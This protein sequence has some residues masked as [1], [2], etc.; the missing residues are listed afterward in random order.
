MEPVEK[1]LNLLPKPTKSK[2]FKF[3]DEK[4]DEIC[5]IFNSN[6][7]YENI[8]QLT[9]YYIFPLFSIRFDIEFTKF[10]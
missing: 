8:T 1:S 6:F 7:V 4:L 3:F 2:Q 10:Q 9:T 5:A